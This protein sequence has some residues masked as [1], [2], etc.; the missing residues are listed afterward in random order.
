M[1]SFENYFKLEEENCD[2][3]KC[4][5]DKSIQL[6]YI[7]FQSL[8]GGKCDIEQLKTRLKL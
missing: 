2:K 8:Y 5:L 1:K 7:W 4:A 6:K 3:N